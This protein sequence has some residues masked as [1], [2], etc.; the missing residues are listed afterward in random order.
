MLVGIRSC[1]KRPIDRAILSNNLPTRMLI[2]RLVRL[3]LRWVVLDFNTILYDLLFHPCLLVRLLFHISSFHLEVILSLN[4]YV[5][6]LFLRRSF[7]FLNKHFL[8]VV[9]ILVTYMRHKH[10]V[11]ILVF[12][13]DIGQ[14][15]VHFLQLVA[16]P[17]LL[18]SHLVK[19]SNIVSWSCRN[20]VMSSY[21][22]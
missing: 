7:D 5:Y 16:I 3:L 6:W 20:R 9:V 14:A 2:R 1:I 4:H 13:V 10:M 22:G 8:L 21:L 15:F 18:I 19:V 17:C 11:L 12:E